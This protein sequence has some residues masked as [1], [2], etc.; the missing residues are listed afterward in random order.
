[1]RLLLLAAAGMATGH[2]AGT[3]QGN[4]PRYLLSGSPATDQGLAPDCDAATLARL[5]QWMELPPPAGGWTGVPQSVEVFNIVAGEVLIG[6]GGR[7][8]CGHM[9]DARSRD[10]RFH[11]GVGMVLVPEAGSGEP[12]MV[13]WTSPLQSNWIPTVRIG[14]PSE[15][16]QID[17][18]LLL[19]RI[20]CLSVANALAFSALL[21]F[22]GTRD[23]AFL[24]YAG[25][26]LLMML[27]QAVLSGLSGYPWAWLPVG[28]HTPRWLVAFAVTGLSALLYVLWQLCGVPPRNARQRRGLLVALGVAWL[29]G[30]ACAV[31]LPP[32]ALGPLA[33]A[34]DIVFRVAGAAMV[35]VGVFMARRPG[36]NAWVGLVAISPFLAMSV[37]DLADSRVLLAYRVEL[38]QLSITWFL[39]MGAYAVNLRLGSLRRQRD[40]MRALV[41]TDALTGLAN[42]RAGLA[43]LARFMRDARARD[44]VLSVA[45][46][47]LDRFKRINDLYGHPV[48][49]RVL[50]AVARTLSAAVRDP[51]DVARIGGEEF[52]VILPGVDGDTA[53]ARMEDIRAHVPPAVDRLGIPGVSATISIGVASLHPADEGPGALLARADAAMY[54]AKRGGRNR[55][56]AAALPNAENAA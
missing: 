18:A 41:D 6:H 34:V 23:R 43:R 11:A 17:T 33:G 31:L 2:A 51:A 9:H 44:G 50:V 13:A 46:L 52:V 45:F 39:T 24:G 36:S 55:V 1:M 8:A 22:L 56:V 37:L 14:A 15:V 20:A 28:E 53:M 10:A 49:D 32:V 47:D 19:V 25:L 30:A 7:M 4:A 42:R 26:C 38:F 54:Q 16:Q 3:D 48:G 21:G 40:E 5:D 29:L 35:P 27:W 12:I